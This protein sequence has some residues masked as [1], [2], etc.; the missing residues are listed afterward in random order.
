[1]NSSR[2]ENSNSLH[3]KLG[4]TPVTAQLPQAFIIRSVLHYNP[5]AEKLLLLGL[6]IKNEVIYEYG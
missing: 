5:T 6:Q 3:L 1:M 2:Q 4:N